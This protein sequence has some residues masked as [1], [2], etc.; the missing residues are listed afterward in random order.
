[1]GLLCLEVLHGEKLGGGSPF[2]LDLRPWDTAPG[3][4][5]KANFIELITRSSTPIRHWKLAVR[6]AIF[7]SL[8]KV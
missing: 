3:K 7:Y 4:E 2:A 6:W 1:M 5:T 8:R